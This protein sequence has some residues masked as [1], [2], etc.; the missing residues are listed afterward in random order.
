M[1]VASRARVPECGKCEVCWRNEA[2]ATAGHFFLC[3]VRRGGFRKSINPWPLSTARQKAVFIE[4]PNILLHAPFDSLP[5]YVS[6]LNKMGMTVRVQ[7]HSSLLRLASAPDSIRGMLSNTR[8][9]PCRR[10]YI[11]GGHT[12]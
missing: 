9:V 10:R 4:S 8:R 12:S 11:Y 6:A 1:A 2:G 7:M 3:V 5:A